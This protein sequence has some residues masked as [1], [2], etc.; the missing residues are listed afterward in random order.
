MVVKQYEYTRITGLIC[1]GCWVMVHCSEFEPLTYLQL[2][3]SV[4]DSSSVLP[5]SPLNVWNLRANA[6]ERCSNCGWVSLFIPTRLPGKKTKK[7]L[8]FCRRCCGCVTAAKWT[9]VC[10]LKT[11][12]PNLTVSQQRMTKTDAFFFFFQTHYQIIYFAIL[13]AKAVN[14]I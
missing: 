2:K 7:K 11:L 13:T 14:L 3:A 6:V 12:T 10:L 9:M 1:D 4:I 5:S 8:P